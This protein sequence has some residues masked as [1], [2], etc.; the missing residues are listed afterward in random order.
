MYRL[1]GDGWIIE[2]VI[3]RVILG[4][5]GEESL[6][7]SSRYICISPLFIESFMHKLCEIGDR[8]ASDDLGRWDISDETFD[9]S[10]GWDDVTKGRRDDL[11]DSRAFD[12]FVCASEIEI[13][14]FCIRYHRGRIELNLIRFEPWIAVDI[15]ECLEILPR[16]RAIES[17]HDMDR[18]LK[19]ILS[20]TMEGLAAL[21]DAMSS[22]IHVED[23]IIGRLD[24]DLEPRDTESSS[25]LAI[26]MRDI[27]W[28]RFD[29]Q[30]D[31]PLSGCL[32]AKDRFF[33]GLRVVV[34]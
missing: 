9:T 6:I 27:L 12:R 3:E 18:K 19:S 1:C 20:E 4:M 22:L 8:G 31:D 5:V 21:L 10:V 34:L 13:I 30:T 28:S 7:E 14:E 26:L 29:G 16:I 24:A 15:L 25:E 2:I 17:W 23:F 32:I 33:D 11:F